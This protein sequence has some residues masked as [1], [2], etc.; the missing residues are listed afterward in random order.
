MCVSNSD[1]SI[2]KPA[3][4]GLAPST[5]LARSAEN[6]QGLRQ[7]RLVHHLPVDLQ[8]AGMRRLS[9]CFDDGTRMGEWEYAFVTTVTAYP[10]AWEVGK[11]Y[12][13]QRSIFLC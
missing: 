5:A 6:L 13:R 10:R 7:M 3:P 9:E 8:R 1:D 11:R 12:P 2:G 4:P